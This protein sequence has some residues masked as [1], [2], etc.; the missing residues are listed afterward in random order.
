[1]DVRQTLRMI[2]WTVGTVV[3]AAFILNAIALA[4]V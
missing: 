3:A 4:A 1:M 2:G